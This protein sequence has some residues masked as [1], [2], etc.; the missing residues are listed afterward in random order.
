MLWGQPS[1]HVATTEAR[2]PYNL[3]F[4]AGEATTMKTHT[5]HLESRPYSLQLEKAQAQ[6][7]RHSAVIERYCLQ[8]IKQKDVYKETSEGQKDGA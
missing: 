2:P 5:P 6:Q 4:A 3:C 8:L 7:G 1:P